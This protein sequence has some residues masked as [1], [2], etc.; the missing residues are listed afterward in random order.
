[1][2]I[3]YD[4]DCDELI[5]RLAGPLSPPE[6]I[7]FNRAAEEALARAPCWGEG[8]VYQAVVALQRTFFSSAAFDRVAYELVS[9]AST[10]SKY[11]FS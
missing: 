1:M 7:A 8:A 5:F 6:R 4:L 9:C 11:V 2:S 3:D 10:I